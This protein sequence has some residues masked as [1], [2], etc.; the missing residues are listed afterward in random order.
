MDMVLNLTI[1]KKTHNFRRYLFHFV[2][3]IPLFGRDA[4][5]RA[6]LLITG[7]QLVGEPSATVGVSCI[8]HVHIVTCN[9]Y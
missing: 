3:L 7:M 4:K 2:G 6:Y 9:F 1:M 8:F 5:E